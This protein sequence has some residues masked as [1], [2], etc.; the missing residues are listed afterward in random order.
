H[1][2]DFL[3]D[4]AGD[5]FVSASISQVGVADRFPALLFHFAF[6]F[7]DIAFDLVFG[8]RFHH[9]GIATRSGSGRTF[10]QVAESQ[11][12]GLEDFNGLGTFGGDDASPGFGRWIFAARGH[13]DFRLPYHKV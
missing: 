6:G 12:A 1:V 2:A 13:L 11:A 4:F 8:A 10:R 7:T 5:L 3:L 9:Y